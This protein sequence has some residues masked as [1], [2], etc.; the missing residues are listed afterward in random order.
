MTFPIASMRVYSRWISWYIS[1]EK[2]RPSSRVKDLLPHI[3]FDSL[4]WGGHRM[5]CERWP[6]GKRTFAKSE[7]SAN[8]HL[9]VRSISARKGQVASS[10]LTKHHAHGCPIHISK[11]GRPTEAHS[12]SQCKC[13]ESLSLRDADHSFDLNHLDICREAWSLQCILINMLVSRRMIHLF[14][15]EARLESR[16]FQQDWTHLFSIGMKAV[17]TN[18][19][20]NVTFDWVILWRLGT[21]NFCGWLSLFLSS[22]LTVPGMIATACCFALD[23]RTILK[24]W[25]IYP[26]LVST[27]ILSSFPAVWYSSWL[28]F[29]RPTWFI[30]SLW[31][32]IFSVLWLGFNGIGS[33]TGRS[34]GLILESRYEPEDLLCDLFRMRIIMTMTAITSATATI[35][36]MMMMMMTTS[37][38]S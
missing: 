13:F 25:T 11:S 32:C 33:T 4:P 19:T 35:V 27:W 36:T 28:S 2:A 22:N 20:F 18:H 9:K 24:T 21:D 38:L 16:R 37:V 17:S 12:F 34:I 8:N 31:W 29:S 6:S 10:S 23:S 7:K 26:K 3:Q 14:R 30:G 5:K 1:E 15:S